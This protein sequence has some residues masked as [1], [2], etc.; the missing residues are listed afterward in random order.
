MVDLKL[1]V[2]QAVRNARDARARAAMSRV[3]E[4]I[5]TLEAPTCYEIRWD[6][7]IFG[8]GCSALFLALLVTC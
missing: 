1:D 2:E 5:S 8:V 3:E 7:V 4:P 6:L